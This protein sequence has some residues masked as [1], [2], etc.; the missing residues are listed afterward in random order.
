MSAKDIAAF[1]DRVLLPLL[2]GGEVVPT[3]PLAPTDAPAVIAAVE[4][5]MDPGDGFEDALEGEFA[6]LGVLGRARPVREEAARVALLLQ[7]LV[8][9]VD[10][11]LHPT[12]PKGP[13]SK[14]T[15]V[16]RARAHLESTPP[17]STRGEVVTRHAALLCGLSARRVD[18]AIT[19]WAGR[20]A[21]AGRPVPRGFSFLQ[22]VRRVRRFV[23]RPTLLALLN[24]DAVWVAPDASRWAAI[25]PLSFLARTTPWVAQVKTPVA[26]A[27][28]PLLVSVLEDARL[29]GVLAEAVAGARDP[30]AHLA[31][32]GVVTGLGAKDPRLERLAADVRAHRALLTPAPALGSARAPRRARTNPRSASS[33]A[34]HEIP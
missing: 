29:A 19:F 20:R 14:A 30:E 21:Y 5:C 23:E 8:R 16:A 6:D 33:V 34:P 15:A 11:T 13:R 25:S 32:I 24:A 2:T 18:T 4:T 28:G 27:E 7:E 12:K 10:P 22:G 31:W 26:G 17:P 1:Y 3:G 9:C